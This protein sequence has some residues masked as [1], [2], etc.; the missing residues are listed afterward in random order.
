MLDKIAN[1]T[2]DDP[3]RHAVLEGAMAVFLAYGYQRA[4][5]E[6]IARSAEMSRPA[7][8]LLFR[9]KADIYRALAEGVFEKCYNLI[10][11]RLAHNDPLAVRLGSAIE[12]VVCGV[13][14]DIENTPHG[15]ELIDLKASL[16]ADL[17]GDWMNR[18]SARYAVAIQNDADARGVDL[19][20]RGLTAIGIANTMICAIDGAKHRFHSTDEQRQVILDTV[21]VV[22]LA[23]A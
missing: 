2:S 15:R 8:Y 14:A 16:A 21:R 1:Q 23:M 10:D 18:I 6:D 4:T 3:K 13:M 7:L 5:M 19:S 9:N 20:A 12:S 17:I 22:E 11:E